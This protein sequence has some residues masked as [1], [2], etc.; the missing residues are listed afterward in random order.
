MRRRFR[1]WQ[2][3][4]KRAIR[5]AGW[6]AAIATLLFG[7]SV[8]TAGGF[9]LHY[10]HR[11]LAIAVLAGGFLVVTLEGSYRVWD[12][13]DRELQRA[14]GRLHE[15]D[16]VAAKKEYLEEAV[17]DLRVIRDE[18]SAD[19]FQTR[20]NWNPHSIRLGADLIHL[21]N[22]IRATLRRSFPGRADRTF[23]SDNS[24]ASDVVHNDWR[25]AFIEYVDRRI[26][27]LKEIGGNL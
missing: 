21:E 17:C 10:H 13:S 9:L 8:V 19:E 2:E 22:E 15:L 6:I 20:A 5:A 11:I 1:H 24:G 7:G 12:A 27:R 14:K 3:V 26:E 18:A 23:D 4:F 25:D 16:T